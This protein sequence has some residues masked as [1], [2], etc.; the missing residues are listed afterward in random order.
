MHGNIYS[1]PGLL[2]VKEEANAEQPRDDFAGVP[3]GSWQLA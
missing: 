1:F 3:S 2:V